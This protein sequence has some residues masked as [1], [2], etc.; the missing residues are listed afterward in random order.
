METAV[1]IEYPIQATNLNEQVYCIETTA[2][3]TNTPFHVSTKSGRI[4]LAVKSKIG[5]KVSL[6]IQG[7]QHQEFGEMTLNACKARQK[8]TETSGSQQ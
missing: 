4:L 6:H 3:S 5:R 8:R 1:T 2:S 7:G